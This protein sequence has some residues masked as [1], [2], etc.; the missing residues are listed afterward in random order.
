MQ[1]KLPPDINVTGLEFEGPELVIYTDDPKKLADDG[2]II[3]NLAKELRKRVVVRP[4]LKVL[5]DPELA[6][7]KIQEVVP[8][9]AVLTDYY[10]DGET[11]EVQIEAE[12]PGL[13]IGRHGATLREITKLI[14]WTPK[15]SEP[16]PCGRPPL[17]TSRI[18]CAVCKR[19][20]RTSCAL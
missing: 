16:R 7:T 1:S 13:V 12:K 19:S 11:G 10:F 15:W 2:E 20:E 8:K 9:E 17:P 6:K 14:G 3:R 4:D 5:A 18:T